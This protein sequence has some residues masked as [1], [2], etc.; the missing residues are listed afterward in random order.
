MKDIIK[1]QESLQKLLR[2]K[3]YINKDRFKKICDNHSLEYGKE[4]ENYNHSFIY[5]L[6]NT[7]NPILIKELIDFDDKIQNENIL[8]RVEFHKS[9]NQKKVIFNDTIEVIDVSVLEGLKR[10][11]EIQEQNDKVII[12]NKTDHIESK[13]IKLT[14]FEGDI[15]KCWDNWRNETKIILSVLDDR[16][17]HPSPYYSELLYTEKYGYLKPDGEPNKDSEKLKFDSS[18]FNIDG[19]YNYHVITL[20]EKFEVVGNIFHDYSILKPVNINN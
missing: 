18:L 11:V 20:T 13:G 6:S 9:E 7:E 2:V 15:I 4:F 12:L 14:L 19:N 17:I 3:G 16:F 10:L 8:L 1:L 5:W